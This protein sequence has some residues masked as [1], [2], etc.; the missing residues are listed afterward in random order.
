MIVDGRAIA[1][2]I[3]ASLKTRRAAF[4]HPLTLGILV[5]GANPVIESFVRIKR[6]AAEKLDIAI[7][8][9]DL[10]EL[11]DTEGMVHAVEDLADQTDGIIV[12]LPLLSHLDVETVLSA[13]PRGKDVDSINPSV[14]DRLVDAPVA[15]AVVEILERGGIDALGK[16][17]VVLGAGRLVGTPVAALLEKR[18]ADVHIV[19]L[20]AGHMDDLANADIIVSGAGSPGFIRPEH[21]KEGVALIDAGTSESAGRVV[22]DA[23]PA[24]AEKAVLFTPVP[25][26]VGPIAVAMIFR[27]LLDLTEKRGK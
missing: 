6:A 10:D 17:V 4:G 21:I 16:R 13:I 19:T 12:Q 9:I 7:E 22:G 24:C 25:G 18:G 14:E 15:C 23:D 3:Y 5:S 8:R 20:D 1:D 27:N 2:D 11:A 26:G